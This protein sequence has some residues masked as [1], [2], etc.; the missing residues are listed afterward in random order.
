MQARDHAI[1]FRFSDGAFREQ[2]SQEPAVRQFSHLQA[3]FSDFSFCCERKV[4]SA[5][6]YRDYSQ[7]CFRAEPPVQL[8]L[9]LAK[10]MALFQ[11]AEIK[12][13]QIHRLFHLE[14]EWR[15]DEYPRDVCLNQAHLPWPVG[16]R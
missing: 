5:L 8:K 4:G 11:R 12:E 7:V 6:V 10:V 3:V 9:S 1:N 2:L 14:H 13:S 15:R 16:V